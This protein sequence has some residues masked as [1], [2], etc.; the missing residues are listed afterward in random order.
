M[1]SL[2]GTVPGLLPKKKGRKNS[3]VS[4]WASSCPFS[5]PAELCFPKCAKADG[6]MP[7]D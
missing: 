6:A 4:Y 7:L 1:D 5:L 3:G 2:L